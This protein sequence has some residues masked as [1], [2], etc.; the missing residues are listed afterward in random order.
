MNGMAYVRGHAKDY[1]RWASHGLLGWDYA[2]VLP[3]FKKSENRELG[4]DD[5][6]SEGGPLNVHRLPMTNPLHQ[7]WLKAG[8]QAGIGRTDDQNGHRQAGTGPMDNTI[9]NGERLSTARAFLKPAMVRKNLEVKTRALVSKIDIL[10]GRAVGVQ[11]TVSGKPQA[12]SARREIILSSG[13]INSPQILMLS[14]IGPADHLTEMGIEMKVDAP[15]VGGNLQDHL[16]VYAQY[17]C[18][19]PVSIYSLTK[20]LAKLRVGLEWLINRS[21]PGASCQF[22]TGGFAT[23]SGAS[24]HPDLQWHFLPIAV[25]YDGKNQVRE[26]G[27]QAHVG[28]MHPKSR[29][30]ISLASANYRDAPRIHFNYLEAEDDRSEFRAGLRLTRKI[31]SQAAFD[32]YRGDEIQPGADKTDDADLDAFVRARVESAYHPVGTCR[33]G[34]DSNSV[35]D[36]DAKVRGVDGLRVVD[37]S[38]MPDIVSGNTNAPTIMIAEKLADAIKGVAPLPTQDVSVYEG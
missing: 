21:G 14:G 25:D 3:Y 37:A 22:E 4:A 19:Q 17:K 20:P 36:K 15:D 8:E 34:S 6:H 35:V 7:A 11:F 10:G 16:E 29:G 33:M 27:F 30:R 31:I 12:A 13:T 38:I 18:I 2:S 1:D 32:P 28:P 5:Y 26:H 23:L 9:K 24:G